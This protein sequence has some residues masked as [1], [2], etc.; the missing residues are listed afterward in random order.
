MRRGKSESEGGE[1]SEKE[2]A[3]RGRERSERGREREER[4]VKAGRSGGEKERIC[5]H[6]ASFTQGGIVKDC[7]QTI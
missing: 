5:V 6:T 4:S 1:G 3:E 2:R 7:K